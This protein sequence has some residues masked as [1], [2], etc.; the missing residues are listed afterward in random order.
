MDNIEKRACI[1]VIYRSRL[2]I[3]SVGLALMAYAGRKDDFDNYR[4]EIKPEQE[5]KV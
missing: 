3:S 5:K 2:I 4:M 1:W